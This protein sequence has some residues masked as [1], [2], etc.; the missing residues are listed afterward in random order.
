ML[1]VLALLVQQGP[2]IPW[3]R[4]PAKGALGSEASINVPAGC[5][6]T[7]MDGIK[8]FLTAT[9]NPVNGNE[10]GV[11]LCQSDKSENT[12]FVLFSYDPSGYVKDDE[13]AHL[14]ADAILANVREGTE[15]ANET[16]KQRGWGTLTVDGWVTKPFYDKSTNNLTWAISAHDDSGVGSVNHSVRLLGR[17]GVMHIDLVASPAQLA[18]LVPAFNSMLA[19]FNYQPGF[20][21]AEWR[22]GDKIASYG[23]TALVAGGAGVALAKSGIL[24]KL[25]K[26]IV[27]GIAAVAAGIKR[28]WK[29]I[30]GKNEM[31]P[32]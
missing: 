5:L 30:T 21:Y 25:W 18:G 31:Q 11:V 12:W 2:Q 1:F 14:D 4:G 28:F 8:Q 16:R 24:L 17:G 7:G 19:G 27:A 20:K 6:F 13:G 3:V 26:L 9:Q 10:R 22:P 32:Q 15:A 29:K 23:L